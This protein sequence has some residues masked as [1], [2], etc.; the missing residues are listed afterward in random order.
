MYR[1]MTRTAECTFKGRLSSM[2]SNGPPGPKGVYASLLPSQTRIPRLNEIPPYASD[3]NFLVS[4]PT[5][6]KGFVSQ[7]VGS[8]LCVPLSQFDFGGQRCTAKALTTLCSAKI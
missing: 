5:V 1:R 7:N 4:L 2:E 3:V 8:T 6:A